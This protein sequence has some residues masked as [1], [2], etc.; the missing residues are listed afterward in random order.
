MGS[1][2]LPVF[3]NASIKRTPL[4]RLLISELQKA[5]IRLSQTPHPFCELDCAWLTFCRRVSP[6][7]C[8][9]SELIDPNL[10]ES[11]EISSLES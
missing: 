2:S 9:L 10:W 11:N 1:N 3:L 6:P 8:I 5:K 4:R 7:G